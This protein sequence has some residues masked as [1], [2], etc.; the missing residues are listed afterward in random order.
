MS[1]PRLTLPSRTISEVDKRGGSHNSQTPS[2]LIRP[3]GSRKIPGSLQ[4]LYRTHE[5]ARTDAEQIPRRTGDQSDGQVWSVQSL[6][7]SNGL[8]HFY[9]PLVRPD[10]QFQLI[11][12]NQFT[13]ESHYRLQFAGCSHI[14]ALC[15]DSTSLNGQ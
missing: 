10:N 4:K 15:F 2:H 5:N 3:P 12:Y 6:N 14:L 1:K 7:G 8:L 11:V 9:S 13:N